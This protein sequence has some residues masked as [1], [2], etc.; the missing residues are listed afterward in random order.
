MV[1]FVFLALPFAP[2][3]GNYRNLVVAMTVLFLGITALFIWAAVRPQRLSAIYGWF[4]AHLLPARVR[5]TVEVS[6]PA[7]K[8]KW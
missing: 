7:R 3:P 1:M 5:P 4:S 8:R 2:M 6:E